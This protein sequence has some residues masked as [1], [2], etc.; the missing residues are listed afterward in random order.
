MI[1]G[2]PGLRKGFVMTAAD[3]LGPGA[4]DSRIQASGHSGFTATFGPRELDFVAPGSLVV[5][6][7][8]SGRASAR[9]SSLRELEAGARPEAGEVFVGTIIDILD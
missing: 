8:A 2:L 9:I 7:I 1:E 4:G 3:G 6:Y 5:V